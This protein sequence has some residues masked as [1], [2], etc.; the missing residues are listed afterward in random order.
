MSA[1][2]LRMPD[3]EDAAPSASAQRRE[4]RPIPRIT[5]QAFCESHEVAAAMEGAREDRRM[6]RAH[7]KIQ[8]GGLGAAADFYRDSP[9]PNVLI[10]ETADKRDR[11]LHDLGRLSEVC[12][13]T[14]KVVI[15]GH[16]NDILLYRELM[17][18]GISE[19]VVTPITPLD[20][21]EIVSNLFG[22]PKAKPVGRAIA[23]VGAKG[24]VGS[25]TIAHNVAWTLAG[26]FGL[27]T[28]LADLDL[29]FGT[30]NLD[31][32]Q[33]PTQGIADA[34]LAPERLDATFL[35]RLLVNCG[36]HLNL[37]AAPSTLERTYDFGEGSFEALAELVRSQ[38]PFVVLDMPHMWTG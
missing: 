5:I 19:Y 1:A 35:D 3:F 15:V 31:Y 30:A 4:L 29:P 13:P 28:V 7:L 11:I 34:V 22:D 17:R 2:T 8:T 26:E 21:V 24:G 14:T 6:G 9:T 38:S 37:L 23:F 12:D 20:V 32:N 10:L 33:D 27:G 16:V 36:P 18:L 25:S